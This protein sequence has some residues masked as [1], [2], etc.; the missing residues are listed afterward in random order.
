M[1]LEGFGNMRMNLRGLQLADINKLCAIAVD[2]DW[3]V[4]ARA[5][6]HLQDCG[7]L[8]PG[9]FRHHGDPLRDVQSNSWHVS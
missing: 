4:N 9:L 3:Q 1:H 7:S 6:G 2:K 8:L 5:I